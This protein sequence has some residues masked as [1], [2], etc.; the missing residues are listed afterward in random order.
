VLETIKQ[1]TTTA[2]KFEQCR[3]HEQCT[4]ILKMGT[5]DQP[6]QKSP[7]MNFNKEIHDK[8]VQEI[9]KTGKED[10]HV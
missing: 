1:N 3:K 9:L 5:E 7:L 2:H 6:A 8:T 10:Q 4:Q